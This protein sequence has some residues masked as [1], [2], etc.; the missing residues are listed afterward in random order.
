METSYTTLIHDTDAQINSYYSY[1]L[2]QSGY[3]QSSLS[4]EVVSLLGLTLTNP[5]LTSQSFH[6]NNVDS[7]EHLLEHESFSSPIFAQLQ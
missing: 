1:C 2:N 4:S 7:L 6:H 3:G 5:M